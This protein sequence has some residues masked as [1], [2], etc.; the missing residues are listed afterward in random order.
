MHHMHHLDRRWFGRVA[1]GVLP[2]ERDQPK[3]QG[4]QHESKADPEAT[5]EA[6]IAR[7]EG[8]VHP[9]R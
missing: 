3:S 7:I 2:D 5:L 9:P 6:H 8:A 4:V 1:V